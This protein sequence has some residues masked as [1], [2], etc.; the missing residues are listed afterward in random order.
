MLSSARLMSALLRRWRE[1]CFQV[2]PECTGDLVFLVR[3]LLVSEPLQRILKAV[4][5][6]IG[7]AA[8]VFGAAQMAAGALSAWLAGSGTRH[9]V[10][11]ALTLT[12]ARLCCGRLLWLGREKAG[13]VA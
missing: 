12:A 11:C 2:I 10:N 9:E 3:D 8:G 7:S 5:L 13:A 4:W 1:R 6:L